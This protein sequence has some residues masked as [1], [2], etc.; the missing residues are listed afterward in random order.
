MHMQMN[1][2]ARTEEVD[3]VLAVAEAAGGL[4][5]RVVDAVVREVGL[6]QRHQVVVVPDVRQG[7]P[8]HVDRGHRRRCR[9]GHR[10]E[11]GNN[12]GGNSHG[13]RRG[14]CDDSSSSSSHTVTYVVVR[15]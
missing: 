6:E 1:R 5:A 13:A 10:E 11:E 8:E 14:W 9:R 7:V 4:L 15:A 2:N 12:G 3:G